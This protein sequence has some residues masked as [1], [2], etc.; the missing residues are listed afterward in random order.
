MLAKFIHF[1]VSNHAKNINLCKVRYVNISGGIMLLIR[2][3]FFVMLGL[4]CAIAQPT[5]G[6]SELVH[7]C[8]KYPVC[9]A[10]ITANT[11]IYGVQAYR[12]SKGIYDVK[13]KLLADNREI[14]KG[15]WWRLGTSIFAHVNFLHL[16]MNMYSLYN[17]KV[18]EE[19]L[20]SGK[21]FGLYMASG[22]AAN[23]VNLIFRN[24]NYRCLGASGAV[25]GIL[26][27][28]WGNLIKH[29]RATYGA[30]ALSIG[31]SF[32]TNYVSSL[33]LPN[34]DHG[35]HAVGLLSGFGLARLF[36]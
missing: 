18:A 23:I 13:E 35:T 11:A 31:P 25:Y 29:K 30:A 32:L 22:L 16:A 20:G 2:N 6:S 27:A 5:Q 19:L 9:S 33:V 24:P 8:K 21:F 17:F 7:F 4:L 34:I 10:L 3:Y 14:K 36:S 15:Q 1:W 28:I 26:G 12:E